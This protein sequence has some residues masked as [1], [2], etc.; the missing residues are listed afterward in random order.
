VFCLSGGFVLLQSVWMISTPKYADQF[1]L[2]RS[3]LGY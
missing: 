1:L 3:F 2:F